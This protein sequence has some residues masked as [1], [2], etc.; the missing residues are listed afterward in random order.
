[1]KREFFATIDA[2]MREGI[3]VRAQVK[4]PSKSVEDGGDLHDQ[5]PVVHRT[6]AD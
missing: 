6:G 5:I 3:D 4:R 1:M 2:L